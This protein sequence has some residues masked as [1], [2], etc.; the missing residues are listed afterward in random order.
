MAVRIALLRG[1]NVAGAGKL[2]MAEF[3]DMLAGMGFGS[4][5]TYIQSGNAV[6]DSDLAATRLEA[7]IG[8]AVE[9]RFGFR[10]DVFVLS[11]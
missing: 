9:E 3:R 1:V 4:V 10:R 5:Q 7:T 8:D 11:A 2:P 6:F